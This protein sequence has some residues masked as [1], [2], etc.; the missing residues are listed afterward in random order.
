VLSSAPWHLKRKYQR[1]TI[2]MDRMLE[3]GGCAAVALEDG[4]GAVTLGGGFGWWL[5]MQRQGWAAAVAEDHATMVSASA[6]SKPR[7]T[8]MTLASALARTAREDASDARIC[9]QRLQ[10]D[11]SI[12]VAGGSGSSK[13]TMIALTRQE[14]GD[15]GAGPAQAWQGQCKNGVT[16]ELTSER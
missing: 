8:V 16:A 2:N 13:D 15:D 14:Q 7:A 5:K 4:G 6:L 9:W 10:G 1:T 3:D 12:V 11:R